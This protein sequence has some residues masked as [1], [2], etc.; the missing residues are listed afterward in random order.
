LFII[1]IIFLLSV[2]KFITRKKHENIHN[3][4]QDEEI[5]KKIMNEILYDYDS[6]GIEISDEEIK[7]ILDEKFKKG[8]ITQQ[9][10]N[11]IKDSPMGLKGNN[12]DTEVLNSNE[13]I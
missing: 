5:Y 4:T 2:L 12:N 10:Y 3:P 13:K 8:E 1:V 11:Q 7:S 6:I 9:T